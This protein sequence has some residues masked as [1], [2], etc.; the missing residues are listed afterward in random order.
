MVPGAGVGVGDGVGV[1]AGAGSQLIIPETK[2]SNVKTTKNSLF[3]TSSISCFLYR[4][5]ALSLIIMVLARMR[6]SKK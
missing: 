5:S 4:Y 2:T 6:G 1:W 3:T